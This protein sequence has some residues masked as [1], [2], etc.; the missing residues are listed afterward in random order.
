MTTAPLGSDAKCHPN[1]Q[2]LTQIGH[3]NIVSI[4]RHVLFNYSLHFHPIR[5]SL[6]TVLEREQVQATAAGALTPGP[7][8][9]C[10]WSGAKMDGRLHAGW[11]RTG[12]SLF[13]AA[14]TY[15]HLGRCT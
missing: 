6:L 7:P 13:P 11:G 8:S 9:K 2:A 10:W 4:F 5:D 3:Q 1:A 15:L 14:L 12:Q